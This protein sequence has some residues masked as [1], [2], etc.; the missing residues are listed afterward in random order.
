MITRCK[1]CGKKLKAYSHKLTGKELLKR[2]M[3]DDYSIKNYI[4]EF[5]TQWIKKDNEQWND[6][7]DEDHLMQY[8]SAEDY[9][10]TVF[11]NAPLISEYLDSICQRGSIDY[12]IN[13]EDGEYFPDDF[14]EACIDY[15]NKHFKKDF[16]K[17]FN[18]QKRKIKIV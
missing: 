16:I 9:L 6:D 18:S 11:N 13:D 12:Y 3:E 10:I 4:Y 15:F 8:N 17:E 7:F 1:F 5:Y 2:M 14:E